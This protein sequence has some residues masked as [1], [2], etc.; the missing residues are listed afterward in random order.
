M[1]LPSTVPPE[2]Q[3]I[4]AP[5]PT[6]SGFVPSDLT[7][8]HNQSQPFNLT[9]PYNLSSF[10]SN[11]SASTEMPDYAC[12]SFS[13]HA[14]FAVDLSHRVFL[15]AS[16]VLVLLG[17][18][19][20]TL[21]VLVF[22]SRE[23]RSV[24]SNFYLL[25]LAVSDSCYLLSVFLSKVS[26]ALPSPAALHTHTHTH[27]HTRT[28]MHTQPSR[29]YFSTHACNTWSTPQTSV[30]H[31]PWRSDPADS[32]FKIWFPVT[33]FVHRYSDSSPRALSVEMLCR[34]VDRSLGVL[35]LPQVMT[36]MRCLHMDR[37]TPA[38]LY[39]RSNFMCKL[40]Q[41]TQDV[42]SDY[43]TCLILLFTIER[44]IAVYLPL[45]FKEICTLTRA[46]L[47]CLGLLV[48]IAASTCPYHMI[49]VGLYESYLVCI[50][51]LEYENVFSVLYL[52]EAVVYRIVPVLLIAVFNAFIIYRVVAVSRV[53]RR[54]RRRATCANNN[55]ATGAGQGAGG[56]G[57][58]LTGGGG[59]AVR[60]DDRNRQL[61]IML[62]LVSTSYILTYLP[63]LI[64]YI[65]WKLQRMKT[66]TL[67]NN[68]MLIAQNYSKTLYIAGFAINFLLYTVSGKV[69][70]KQLIFML[71]GQ[72]KYMKT[73]TSAVEM[74]TVV[75][76]M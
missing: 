64:H 65:L 18:I 76:E 70:R 27:A 12:Y 1:D 61:T 51:L 49:M 24:S 30:K 7:T 39:H 26:P 31:S 67:S 57:R 35:S 15:Y 17:L 5:T 45:K 71:C 42:F 66:V 44:L 73:E 74:T 25:M 13:A 8:D 46:K 41:Y 53:R 59:A 6:A 22:T 62:I 33:V 29:S 50:V 9:W 52:I 75:K 56:G 20:N 3:G 19:G 68:G 40:L 37:S 47:V 38:D 69:F 72:K 11:L 28:H 55:N 10:S 48:V 21:S 58:P 54:N 60:K 32:T 14:T 4:S 16:F 23:M 36:D 34:K 43:S 2:V 63:V